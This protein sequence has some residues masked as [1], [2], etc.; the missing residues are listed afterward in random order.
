MLTTE[1]KYIKVNQAIEAGEFYTKTSKKEMTEHTQRLYDDLV[2]HSNP[3][4]NSLPLSKEEIRELKFELTHD[5]RFVKEK[6]YK[7]LAQLKMPV[8]KVAELKSL[9]DKIRSMPVVKKEKQ[10]VEIKFTERQATHLG[11]CQVCGCMHKVSKED[12]TIAKHGYTVAWNSF[13]GE[14]QGS[15][16]LPFEQDKKVKKTYILE[17]DDYLEGLEVPETTG[18]LRKDE[19]AVW[20]YESTKRHLARLI[21]WHC[22]LMNEWKVK[23]LKPI[24]KWA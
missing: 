5:L 16:H 21:E 18:N 23:P 1:Q 15:H 17:L 11:T 9:D 22:K 8:E 6:H 24:E 13:N 2:S 7:I 20:N 14:C 19:I 3:Y 4:N 10:K 12:G